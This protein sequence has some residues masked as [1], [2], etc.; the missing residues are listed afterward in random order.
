ML[1]HQHL[2]HLLDVLP[3]DGTIQIPPPAAE[4]WEGKGQPAPAPAPPR[5]GHRLGHWHLLQGRGTICS[6]NLQSDQN[7]SALLDNSFLPKAL[8]KPMP[9]T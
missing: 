9:W 1:H 3:A 2:Q 5:G 6:H 8:K 7:G 4:G